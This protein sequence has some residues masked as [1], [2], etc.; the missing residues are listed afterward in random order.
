MIDWST[1]TLHWYNKPDHISD[2]DDLVRK[3][4]E[5]SL[6]N[7]NKVSD[8]TFHVIPLSN[9]SFE[10]DIIIVWAEES[11]DILYCDYEPKPEWVS[12]KDWQNNTGN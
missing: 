4:C 12:L 5:E 10:Y 3:D 9:S 6:R 11:D 7:L 1:I 2:Y 8:L